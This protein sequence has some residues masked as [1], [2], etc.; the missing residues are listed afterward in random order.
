MNANTSHKLQVARTALVLDQPFFGALLMRLKMVEDTSHES[1]WTDGVFVGYNPA[2]VDGINIHELQGVLCHEVLH[3]ANG[4]TWRRGHR[5]PK[6]W[7]EA[8][9]YAINPIVV[10]DAKL[11]LPKG[12]LLDQAYKGMSVEQIYDRLR[13]NGDSGQQT[14]KGQGSGTGAQPQAGDGSGQQD[15]P[16]GAGIGEVRDTPD[17]DKSAELES[18]WKMAITQAAKAA[19]MQGKLPGSLQRLVEDTLQVKVDWRSVLH[20]FVQQAARNDYSWKKPNARYMHLGLYSPALHSEQ[21]GPMVVVVDTSGSID[22]G[23][24]GQLS[25][26]L[27][28][29]AGEMRPDAVHVM[30]VDAMVH[31]VDEFAGGEA[32]EFNPVGGGGTDFRPAFDWVEKEG[33]NPSCLVYLTDMMGT[34]P[35]SEPEYPVLWGDTLGAYPAPWG[36]VVPIR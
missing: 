3:A 30:Y 26:E 25:S 32:I 8:C 33:L 21:M 28:A 7:N 34:F 35:E 24:L 15:D 14:Q 36:E 12:A 20:R 2:F 5:D 16:G 17:P 29:I 27:N 11:P 13:Q 31:R 4:H 18:E 9:D 10:D 22:E 23:L 1:M 19:Q 6:R